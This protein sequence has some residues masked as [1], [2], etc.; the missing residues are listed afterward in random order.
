MKN[1]DLSNRL[2]RALVALAAALLVVALTPALASA[3]TSANLTRFLPQK[4]QLVV[5]LNVDK[6]RQSKYFKEAL[7]WAHQNAGNQDFLS[8]LE[9]QGHLDVSKDIDAIVVSVPATNVNSNGQQKHFT[10]A[11]AGHFEKDKLV[12]AIKKKHGDFKTGKHGKYTVY[13]KGNMEFTFPKDGVMWLTTGSD[14]YRKGAWAAVASAKK[15]VQTNPLFNG[16]LKEVNTS[17]GV[18]LMGDTAHM[19]HAKVQGA[20]SH[21]P[22]SIALSVDISKGLDLHMFAEMATKKDAKTAIEQINAYKSQG[23]QSAMLAMMGAGPL[24]TN[25]TAKQD[26]AKLRASTTMTATQFDTMVQWLKQIA[27]SQ[28]QAKGM[29]KP[30]APVPSKGSISAPHNGKKA[31]FN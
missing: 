12:A 14:A 23:G 8:V 10:V 25:L 7:T 22:K 4:T 19:A 1:Y 21:P 18:W 26:G 31:D 3:Q 28:M 17:Q 5:G 9:K 24:L 11:L 13:S 2:H 29:T 20:Q 27:Q 16:L 15:S 6:L 30:S